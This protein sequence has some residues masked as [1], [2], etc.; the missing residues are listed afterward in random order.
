MRSVVLLTVALSVLPAALQGAAKVDPQ[1]PAVEKRELLANHET[2]AVFDGVNYRLCMGRTARC[3]KQ[4][5]DSGEFASFTI[6]KYLKYEKPGEYGDPKQETFLVQV[7]DYDKR[8]KGDPKIA[9]TVKR[10]KKGDYVLLSWHH[11]YV[12]RGGSSFPERPI[13]KL[14][15]VAK[16]KA[17]G[18]LS[19]PAAEEQAAQDTAKVTG[20]FVVPKDVAS[21]DR[22]VVEIHLF[23]IHPLLADKA[24]EVVE[25]LEI[26][27]FSHTKGTETK[28]EFVVGAKA[29]L[30]KDMKYYLTLFFLKDGQRTHMGQVPGKFLC[31]VLT[32]GEPCSVT[33]QV[34]PVR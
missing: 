7:S 2:L 32:Q 15:S 24:A 28:K 30:E 16:E 1:R 9:E 17:E 6:K 19:A 18:L 4:C 20:T 14:E 26:K 33:L 29:Q 23:K 22:R 13:V 10:L 11:D 3:P 21:F 5:G 25:K 8:P 27:D 12:T 34:R 31:T